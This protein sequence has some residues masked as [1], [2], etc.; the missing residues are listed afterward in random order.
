MKIGVFGDSFADRDNGMP[1]R[2]DESW[3]QCLENLG[4]T[5]VSYGYGG[6][7]TYW[8][9]EQFSRNFR[10]FDHIIFC[11]SSQERIHT[12]PPN[13][14]SF[15]SMKSVDELY[16]SGRYQMLTTE[17]ELN[18]NRILTGYLVA[19]NPSFNVFVQQ[20]IFDEVNLLCARH[21]IKLINILP[22]EGNNHNFSLN[23]DTRHGDCLYNLLD[24]VYKEVGG[25]L[26]FRDPRFCHL[27][28]ENNQVLANIV[29]ESLQKTNCKDIIDLYKDTRFIYNQEIFQRYRNWH[30]QIGNYD[31]SYNNFG[32]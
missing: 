29:S 15:S 25:L 13:L 11:Y 1:D 8:S 30:A 28:T 12:L 10:Q 23:L 24:I 21:N 5:I 14:E 17:E 32:R 26:K 27:S 9:F 4:H 6:T 20:K 2:K 31:K 22:F 19:Y 7:S 18:L 16:A 3:M